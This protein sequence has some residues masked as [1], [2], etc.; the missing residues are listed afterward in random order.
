MA[1]LLSGIAESRSVHLSKI[2]NKIPLPAVNS[3]ITRRLSRFLDNPAVRVRRWYE[4]VVRRL[5]EQVEKHHDEFRLIVDGSKIGF[6]HQLLIVSIGW[7]RRALPLAWTWVKG[8]RGHSSV[9]VQLAL[10]VY[11]RSLLPAGH[12]V[13]LVG[14]NEFGAIKI[15]QQLD[16]WQWHYVLRQQKSHRVQLTPDGLWPSFG[17]L[18]S[19]QGQ[20]L[21]FPAANLTQKW[22]YDVNLV[23]WWQPG[24][25]DP[26]LLAT[27]LPSLNEALKAYRRR[28]WIEAMFADFKRQGFDLESTH[29]RHFQRLSRLTL[30][31]VLLYVWLVSYGSYII[32]T[33]Q[34]HFV[35]RRDRRDLS[36]FRIGYDMVQRRLTRALKISITFSLHF[37]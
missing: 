8:S 19:R 29:L 26:W 5:I 24:E 32:K 3:S 21:W 28:M 12:P 31:V 2:A 33:G 34:R 37:T 9:R 1:L 30:A 4:P 17:E 27:N 36:L 15:L 6:N 23:A 18:I 25:K 10:L 7:R 20:R 35:D 13:L 22:A 16:D 14:D 11:V